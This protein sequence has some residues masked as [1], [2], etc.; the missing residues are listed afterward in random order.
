AAARAAREMAL[1]RGT[2]ARA[3]R[4]PRDDVPPT[5]HDPGPGDGGRGPA[6]RSERVFPRRTVALSRGPRRARRGRI[7][8][9]TGDAGT[10]DRTLGDGPGPEGSAGGPDRCATGAGRGAAQERRP[11]A[12]G[13]A[14]APARG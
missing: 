3:P 7:P 14:G 8:R 5:G 4:A 10:L 11:G 2:W 9:P 1:R 13:R 12:P 6:G